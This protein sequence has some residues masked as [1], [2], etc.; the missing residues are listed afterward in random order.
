LFTLVLGAIA[1]VSLVV[2]GIGIMNIMLATVT[3]RTK[4]IGIRRALGA[5]QRDIALQFLV[6]TV[7]LSCGGGI[8]GVAVGIAMTYLL[9]WAADLPAIIRLWSPL[10]AFAVS[11]LVGLV[12][13]RHAERRHWTQSRCGMSEQFVSKELFVVR[14]DRMSLWEAVVLGSSRDSRS[15]TDQPRICLSLAGCFITNIPKTLTTAIQLGTR[16]RVLLLP[17]RP[18]V[19]AR[20]VIMT[21]KRRLAS[22]RST[23]LWMMAVAS[24]RSLFAARVQR[25][26]K[27][28]LTTRK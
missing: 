2:G 22:Y 4:E 12:S 1:G 14:S 5:K 9:T 15:F 11:V 28:P 19:I 16:R 17:P 6:E 10:L 23:R 8:L 26:I 7:T 25:A 13:T 18:W 20:A 3:E 27:G 21:S 24:I